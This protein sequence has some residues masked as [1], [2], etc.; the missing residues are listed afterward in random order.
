MIFHTPNMMKFSQGPEIF[1]PNK[2]KLVLPKDG[3]VV[4]PFETINEEVKWIPKPLKILLYVLLGLG[5][6]V[7]LFFLFVWLIASGV[8]TVGEGLGF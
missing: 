7:G 2:R 4:H 1:K 8:S 5:V 6:I 3:K